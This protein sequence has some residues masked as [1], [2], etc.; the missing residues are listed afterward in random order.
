LTAARDDPPLAVMCAE[1]L[2]WRCH[3]RL[4]ADAVTAAGVDVVH[5]LAIDKQQPHPTG[6]V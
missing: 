3:R 5:V 2:W 1:T 6:L 4:I